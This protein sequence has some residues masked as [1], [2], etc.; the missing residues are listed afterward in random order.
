MLTGVKACTIIIAI[1][2]STHNQFI[3]VRLFD[4]E[5]LHMNIALYTIIVAKETLLINRQSETYAPSTS[6]LVKDI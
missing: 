4:G 5:C 6:H 3:G 2:Q 1:N